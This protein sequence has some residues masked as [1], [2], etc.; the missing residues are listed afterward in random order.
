MEKVTK[1]R[2]LKVITENR[3]GILAEITGLIAE[4]GVNIEKFYACVADEKAIFYLITNNNEK[5]K[6]AL[7]GKGYQIEEKEVIVLLLWNRPGALSEVATRFRE[8]GINLQFVYGTSSP[9]GV[10]TTVVF[11]SDDDSKALE[12]CESMILKEAEERI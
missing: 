3:I 5:A 2:E 8:K 11:S 12:A 9:D 4:K 10:S 7:E 1:E 6:N